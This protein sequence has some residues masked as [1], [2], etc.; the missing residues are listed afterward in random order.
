MLIIPINLELDMKRLPLVQLAHKSLNDYEK[1]YVEFIINSVN[2]T[3]LEKEILIKSEIEKI[4][5]ESVCN[6]LEN[7]NKKS[8]CSYSNCAK[9]KRCAMIKIGIFIENHLLAN[10]V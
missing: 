5:L 9:I 2:L 8:V 1:S 4:D 10:K 7:W 6:S 3:P